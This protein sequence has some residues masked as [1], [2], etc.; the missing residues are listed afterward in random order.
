MIC[1]D[2][3]PIRSE[4]INQE[5]GVWEDVRKKILFSYVHIKSQQDQ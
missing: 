1:S 5:N 3:I 2:R 4:I